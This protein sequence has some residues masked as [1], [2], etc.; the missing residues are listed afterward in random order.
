MFPRLLAFFRAYP[1]LFID[2][3]APA[4]VKYLPLVAFLYFIVPVDLIPDFI[5]ILGEVDDITVI[6]VLMMIAVR[7]FE[8][9]PTQKKQRKYGD[10]IDVEAVKKS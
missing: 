1:K 2:P 9:S 3:K 10:V 7:A 4:K 6:L 8:Q 5:P